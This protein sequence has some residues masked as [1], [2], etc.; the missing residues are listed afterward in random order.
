MYIVYLYIFIGGEARLLRFFH[1]SPSMKKFW[2]P[3]PH[4]DNIPFLSSSSIFISSHNGKRI[5]TYGLLDYV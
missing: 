2:F 4:K 1:F 5:P 3:S